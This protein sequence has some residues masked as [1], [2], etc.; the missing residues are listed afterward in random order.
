M[1]PPNY[2]PR[3]TMIRL[4]P[5]CSCAI[6]FYSEWSNI[7]ISE[8]ILDILTLVL[9]M[10]NFQLVGHHHI[11]KTREQKRWVIGHP[12]NYS[13]TINIITIFAQRVENLNDEVIISNI[14]TNGVNIICRQC[15]IEGNTQGTSSTDN[16]YSLSLSAR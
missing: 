3:A 14:N 16:I 2:N 8:L 13:R 4:S 10:M 11:C 6:F 9:P 15:A 5:C 12:A 7:L 1:L